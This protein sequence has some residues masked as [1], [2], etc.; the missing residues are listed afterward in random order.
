VHLEPMIYDHLLTGGVTEALSS[1]NHICL[2]LFR[3][4]NYYL[5]KS[6][7]TRDLAL[8]IKDV[9]NNHIEVLLYYEGKKITEVY[10]YSIL[11]YPV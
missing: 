9:Q 11:A 3:L 8:L 10:H 5:L 7:D 6:F 1:C 4:L 2:Y